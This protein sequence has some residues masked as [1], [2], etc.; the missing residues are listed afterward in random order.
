MVGTLPAWAV[1]AGT[2]Q[3]GPSLGSNS[4][5]GLDFHFYYC[6]TLKKKKT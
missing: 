3:R 5:F 1:A 2:A 6:C 4:S